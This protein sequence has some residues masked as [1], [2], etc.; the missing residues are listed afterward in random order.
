MVAQVHAPDD[1]SRG[2]LLGLSY[3]QFKSDP[4]NDVVRVRESAGRQKGKNATGKGNR[5]LARTLGEAV[6]AAARTDTF[7]GERYRRLARRRGK[8]KAI[9]AVGR[10]I[11]VIIWHLL[12]NPS[13]EYIDLGP[14][15]YDTRAGTQRAVR[16]H[17][18]GLQALGYSVTLSPAA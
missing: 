16:N 12:A 17:I 1:R 3:P 18:R 9:V 14:H 6:V 11:L 5:Y 4:V 15:H 7:L 10:S 13:A 2:P 8:K